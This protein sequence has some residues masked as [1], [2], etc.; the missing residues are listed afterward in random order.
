MSLSD[1]PQGV[2]RET[3]P[4]GLSL[5]KLQSP[6]M[7]ATISLF[8]GQ[9]LEYRNPGG[10]PLLYLSPVA[11][12][13]NGQPLRGG[14]PIC[15]PWFARQTDVVDAKQHGVARDAIWTLQQLAHTEDGFIIDLAGPAY[16]GLC[17]EVRYRLGLRAEM[18]LTTRNI[19][20]T[21][22]PYSATLHTYLAVGDARRAFI[23]GLDGKHYFDKLTQTN[24]IFPTDRQ[25]WHGGFDRIVYTDRDVT[26]HDPVW[27]RT[28]RVVAEGAGTS[29][30]WNPG[31][32]LAVANLPEGE[33][34]NFICVEAAN[35]GDDARILPPGGSHALSTAFICGGYR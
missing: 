22:C 19:G 16:G 7:S 32:T 2:R 34:R 27:Q 14:I 17:C 26:L 35:A 4:S 24:E 25:V 20:P 3:T 31:P 28:I 8:G 5:L 10:H 29:V 21:P 9:L 11:L 33:W 30:I 15:W 13:A 6:A 18:T 12:Q 23:S 1:A